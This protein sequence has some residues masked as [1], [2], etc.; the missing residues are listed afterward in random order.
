MK[1][2]IS[3]RQSYNDDS[4]NSHLQVLLTVHIKDTLLTSLHGQAGKHP[5]VSRMMQEIRQK[6]NFPSIGNHVR[7]W[8]QDYQTCV[9]SKSVS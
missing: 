4:D 2:D 1:D 9:S 5:S 7:N 3:Y 6:Y 8:V